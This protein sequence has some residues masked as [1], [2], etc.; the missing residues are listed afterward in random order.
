MDRRQFKSTSIFRMLEQII[1]SELHQYRDFIE[2]TS[3]DL[4]SKI[5]QIE[6]EFEEIKGSENENEYSETLIDEYWRYDKVFSKLTYNPMLSSVYGFLEHWLKKICEYDNQK[7]FSNISVSDLSG[8]NYIEKSRLYLEKIAFISLTE[9]EKD[10][11]RIQKVQQI[12]N[13]ITH[14]NSNIFKGNSKINYNKELFKL[15][16]NEES[17]EFDEKTGNFY[18]KN[19]K[20]I[21]EIVEIV[22]NYLLVICEKISNFYS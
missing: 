18:I 10:W 4:K 17:I 19:R 5:N 21:L 15:L 2:E 12:R 13:L 11:V 22:E 3:R 8:R 1:R 7:G 6:K 16:Q 14:N 9:L 20:F